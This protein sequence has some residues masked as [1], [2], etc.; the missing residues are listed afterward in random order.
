MYNSVVQAPAF[1]KVGIYIRLSQEDR[2]KSYESDSESVLNQRTILNNYVNNKGFTFVKEYVDDGY[3]GTNFDRPS[4]KE[5]LEDINNGLINCVITKDLSRFG[6][7]HIMTGYYIE[8]YFVEKGIRYIAVF[9]N[10]DTITEIGTSNDMMAMRSAMN[11]MYSRDNSKKIRGT[12]N[13]KKREGKFIGSA[14]CFGYMRDPDD[15][16]HLI[17]NPETAPV[18]KRIFALFANNVGASD[19]CSI[20]NDE[21]VLT[22]SKYKNTK[23]SSRLRDNDEW[24]ISSIRKIIRNQMYVGDMVQSK[25]AKLSYKSEKKILLDKS[26]WIIIPNTHEP[27]V[28]RS[29][30]ES[31]QNRQQQPRGIKAQRP[32]RLFEHL[33]FC[34]ECG[35]RLGVAYRKNHDYWTVNC[36]RYARDPRRHYCSPHF[37]PYDLLEEQLLTNI[38][39]CIQKFF[40]MLDIDKLNKSVQSE[41]KSDELTQE[42][43]LINKKTELENNLVK[44]YEDK[45]NGILSPTM[46]LT[47]SSRIEPQIKKIDDE[48]LIIKNKKIEYEKFKSKLPDYRNKI[49]KLLDIENPSRELLFTI[50]DKIVIDEE[51]NIKI[52]FKFNIVEPIIFK[53]KEID[54]VKNPYGRAGKTS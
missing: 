35:N 17:P 4:F 6:R 23:K 51:R 11:D 41:K 31:L 12:L 2:G 5:M 1:Y 40:N 44:V 26:L 27:L 7:D 48:L 20:L 30:W 15:K 13:E 42:E 10:I 46:Y 25:Q 38:K 8:Q 54:K 21:G 45:L 52:D 29:V 37:Y 9:D 49:K 53:Y 19:I 28:D 34:K 24:S 14:P 22:P 18:V 43:K 16:N 39:D 33:L 50:I 47:M 36:N 3:S 32:V